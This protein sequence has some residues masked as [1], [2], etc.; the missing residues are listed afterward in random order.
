MT[1]KSWENKPV[2]GTRSLFV[3]VIATLSAFGVSFFLKRC[4][5]N[6]VF[7]SFLLTAYN[8][9]GTELVLTIA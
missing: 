2:T 3:S 4:H 5:V 8:I 6:G 7:I 9:H 1:K